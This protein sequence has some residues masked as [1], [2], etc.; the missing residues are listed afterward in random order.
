MV[1]LI[2]GSSRGLGSEIALAL[3]RDGH[4]VAVHYKDSEDRAKTV[5]S[6]IERAVLL[7]ADVR[8]FNLCQQTLRSL[9]DL[10][11]NSSEFLNPPTT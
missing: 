1:C 9:N 2:T 4:H 7:R 6:R 3:G 10:P 8:K 11:I 5:A